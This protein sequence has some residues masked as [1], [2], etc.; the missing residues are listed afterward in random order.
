MNAESCVSRG[1]LLTTLPLVTQLKRPRFPSINKKHKNIS[2]GKE[3]E[4]SE[5]LANFWLGCKTPEGKP[6][7]FAR[8]GSTAVGG[9]CSC[10]HQVC[11][12]ELCA[13][14]GFPGFCLQLFV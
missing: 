5:S 14:T 13:P 10:G 8:C 9:E 11:S 1:A 4:N 3:T 7:G 2:F 12:A 6:G